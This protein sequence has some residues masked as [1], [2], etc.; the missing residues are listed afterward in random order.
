[1][2]SNISLVFACIGFGALC[3]AIAYRLFKG[4]NK[5]IEDAAEILADVEDS[6]YFTYGTDERYPYQLGWTRVIAPS[7]EAAIAAFR[8]YHPNRSGSDLINCASIY[9]ERQF[10]ATSLP[11]EGNGG[12]YAHE[13]IR[14]N[15]QLNKSEGS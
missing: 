13:Y 2:S 11:F 4:A 15:R 1:M 6:Y 10:Y 12:V 3:L 8:A 9:T 7:Y 5:I 14:I